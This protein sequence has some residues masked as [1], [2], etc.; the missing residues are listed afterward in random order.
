MK[1]F[2]LVHRGDEFSAKICQ[3]IRQTLEKENF[4]YDPHQPD[5]II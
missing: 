5:L 1:K 2:T 3:R 4:T